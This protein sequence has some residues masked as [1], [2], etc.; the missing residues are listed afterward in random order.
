MR[1]LLDEVVGRSTGGQCGDERVPGVHEAPTVPDERLAECDNVVILFV[2]LLGI[3]NF[4]LHKAVLESSHP[5]LAQLRW[6]VKR[7]GG[8]ASLLLELG[9]LIAAMLLVADGQIGWAWVYFGYSAMN[10]LASWL[11]L[12]R[13]L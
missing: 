4:T 1:T 9:V 10:A 8:R 5:L 11:I 12:T 6:L 13:R 3:G 7:L 2:F